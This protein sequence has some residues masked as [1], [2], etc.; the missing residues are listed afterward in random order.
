MP[1][2]QNAR[3]QESQTPIQVDLMPCLS[4]HVTAVACVPLIG[5]L[6][7]GLA[8]CISKRYADVIVDSSPARAHNEQ[9]SFPAFA[10]REARSVS[11]REH[12]CSQFC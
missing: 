4:L 1:I 11:F 8:L 2:C 3:L 5:F 9:A 7:L 10:H 6:T 12:L